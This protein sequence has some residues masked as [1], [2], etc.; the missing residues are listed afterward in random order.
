MQA[1]VERIGAAQGDAA[2]AHRFT[3]AYVLVVK[4]CRLAV[5]QRVAIDHVAGGTGHRRCG[6]A[7]VDLID[8]GV[9]GIQ[10]LGGDVDICRR[11]GVGQGVVTHICAAGQRNAGDVDSLASAYIFSRPRHA[12]HVSKSRCLAEVHHVATYQSA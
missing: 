3:A 7:V 12:A 8:T 4:D 5:G 9:A 2:N 1:V 6:V 11:C 10:R